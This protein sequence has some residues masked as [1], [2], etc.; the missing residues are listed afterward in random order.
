MRRDGPRERLVRGSA[1]PQALSGAPVTRVLRVAL[2]GV[3]TAAAR[4]VLRRDR[5]APGPQP[6]DAATRPPTEA[7]LHRR[8]LAV[9][10]GRRDGHRRHRLG[11]D[12]LRRG[13]VPPPQRRR[14]P[15]ADALQ[16]ADRDPLHDRPGHHGASCSSTTPCDVQDEVLDA[17]R[18]PRPRPSRSSA[19]SGRGRSTTSERPR[20]DRRHG[21]LRRRAP[22]RTS[23]RWCC[24]ST[25]P[26]SSTCT[27]PTSSTPSGSRRSCM[28]MD[29]IPGR[30]QPAS[31]SPRPA[32][33][34]SPASAPSSAASTTR[35]CSSTSRSSARPSTTP[36][37]R[38]RATQGNT[39]DEPLLGGDDVHD[40]GRPRR[41][42]PRTEHASDRAPRTPQ[43][44]QHRRPARKTAGPAGR[45]VS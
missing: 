23:R 24:R 41:Q 44:R 35:G 16:P 7:V 13:R 17:R 29:V 19:S 28:K 4:P 25:R 15:G 27:R 42:T 30:D 20:R 43:H 18:Q 11:P 39:A 45:R 12:L 2:L 8:P 33:A 31:R 10:L 21:R 5:H 6:G 22:R 34:P 38:P 37:R 9:G 32:R 3:T 40:A 14:D 26:S 36:P 1:T